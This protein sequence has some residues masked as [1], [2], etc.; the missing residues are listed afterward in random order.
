[1][2]HSFWFL[3][4]LCCVSG[5]VYA[6]SEHFGFVEKDAAKIQAVS[7]IVSI[8]SRRDSFYTAYANDIEY[9][10]FLRLG[11]T[12]IPLNEPQTKAGV[13]MAETIE[14]MRDWNRYP[15]YAVYLELMQRFVSQY[16]R[17]CRIDTIGE[18]VKGRKIL[19]LEISDSLKSTQAKPS[20]FYSSSIHGDELTGFVLMLRLADHLLSGYGNNEECTQLLRQMRI[21]INPLSNPDGAY[22]KGN[23]NVSGATRYNANSIDLNRNYPDFWTGTPA[24]I[25]KENEAMMR[26]L[27]THPF[28]M[29]VNIHGGADVLNFPWDG[30]TSKKK[31]HADYDWW[32]RISKR[33]V[34]SCRRVDNQAYRDV[35]DNGYIHGGDWYV[36][37]N[38]RQDYA[39]AYLHIRE[40]TLE[41]SVTKMPAA[42]QLPK[43]WN[44]NH[45]SLLNYMKEACHGLQGSV[46]DSLSGEPLRALVE[47]E[48]HDKDSSQVYSSALHGGFFRPIEEG[49]YRLR[50]SAPGYHDKILDNVAV[51]NLSA[52]M[53]SVKL[54]PKTIDTVPVANQETNK[55]AKK[56]RVYPNPVENTLMLSAWE[57]IEPRAIYSAT[58]QH[59]NLPLPKGLQR[60][61][62]VDV[63]RLASGVYFVEVFFETGVVSNLK[64]TKR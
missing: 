18:S 16:P 19:C 13:T 62:E 58:G 27:Q 61:H 25:Q 41:I 47:V 15:T 12:P 36:V 46:T 57:D 3:L 31:K 39:N 9:K 54:L 63:S 37:N 28:T 32:V 55:V 5:G 42:S 45:R 53:F 2:K 14:E 10:Q 7:R 51:Q 20:F 26:Y 8:D 17:L 38:G 33:Y 4:C 29:S 60:H 35:N 64:F 30:F 23:D 34:D 59:L 56:I 43:F 44:V 48:N 50:F 49:T 40:Q 24:K 6:Q 22:A 11:Y 21:F 1:M 52:T